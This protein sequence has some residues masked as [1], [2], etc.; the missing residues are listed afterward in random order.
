ME[1][2]Q[3]RYFVA[4][5]EELHFGR[6]AEKLFI[7]QP[8]LSLQIQKLEKELGVQLFSRTKRK[9]E[10]TP[11]GQAFYQRV[12]KIVTS[13][14]LAVEDIQRIA[15]GEKDVIRVGYMSA[16]MLVEFSPMLRQFHEQ[17]PDVEL[18]LHHMPSDKQ[19]DALVDGR[20]DCAFVD[21]RVGDMNEHFRR[22]HLDG[23]RV[24]HERLYIGV[25]KGHRLAKK[26]LI[27]LDSLFDQEF[28]VFRRRTFPSFYDL[29]ISLCR[30]AG[31]SPGNTY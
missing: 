14:E 1:L 17:T 19:Y 6:A 13:T 4:V 21:L 25:P 31:F 30:N 26:R 18:R 24:L 12:K 10:L 22:Y 20:I 29:V 3:L 27:S 8:P 11:E 7:S 28:I 9:V 15:T 2:R 16:I 5:A 23:R